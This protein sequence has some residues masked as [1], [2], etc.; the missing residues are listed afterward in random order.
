MA[1]SSPPPTPPPL[2][3]FAPRHCLTDCEFHHF[4]L[5]E[6]G[7]GKSPETLPQFPHQ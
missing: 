5:S 4:Y 3:A 6:V 1:S 2:L 7:P